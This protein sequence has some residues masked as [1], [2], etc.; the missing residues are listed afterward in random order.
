MPGLTAKA[1][2]RLPEKDL[3]EDLRTAQMTTVEGH[4]WATAAIGAT[5]RI[6]G[7]EKARPTL[8]SVIVSTSL[9]HLIFTSTKSIP[10]PHGLF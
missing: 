7:K 1:G 9:F 3:R 6:N 10:S 2:E 4:A 5:L 8:F